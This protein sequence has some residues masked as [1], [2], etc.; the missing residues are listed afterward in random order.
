MHRY[1]GVVCSIWNV[2]DQ[3]EI[4]CS[5]HLHFHE[6]WPNAVLLKLQE[7][8]CRS[9]HS[10]VT[11][12]VYTGLFIYPWNLMF[13]KYIIKCW[14]K[15]ERD[16]SWGTTENNAAMKYGLKK[17]PFFILPTTQQA[18]YGSQISNRI[19]QLEVALSQHS[20][21]STL[22]L[23]PCSIFPHQITRSPNTLPRCTDLVSLLASDFVPWFLF[24]LDQ[25]SSNP[26]LQILLEA[27]SCNP[28]IHNT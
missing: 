15:I 5:W 10:Y 23:T 13:P 19:N 20:S 21:K 11:C 12:W 7:R 9:L 26:H 6:V 8:S 17:N 18:I 4:K 14:Y 1:R 2:G 28:E 24:S 27:I 25:F 16:G 22:P 3:R